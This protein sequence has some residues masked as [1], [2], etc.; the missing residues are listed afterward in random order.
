LTLAAAPVAAP[1]GTKAAADPG[2]AALFRE[3]C[4]SCHGASATGDGPMAH[5]LKHTPPDLTALSL[6][7]NGIFPSARI[8]RIIE[9]RDVDS[10]GDRNMPVWGDV[11]KDEGDRT[12]RDA[13]RKRIDAIVKYLESIQRRQA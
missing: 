2:G 6:N 4:A 3:R 10:H 12:T 11:F 1:Q 5:A 13:T 7:N 8:S 9:G